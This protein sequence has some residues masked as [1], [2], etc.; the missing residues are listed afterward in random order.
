MILKYEQS[1]K[2][3]LMACPPFDKEMKNLILVKGIS[4]QLT[5]STYTFSSMLDNSLIAPLTTG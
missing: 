5:F 3:M 1:S 4:W 2:I